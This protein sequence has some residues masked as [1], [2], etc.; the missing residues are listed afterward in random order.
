[1]QKD[2]L[3]ELTPAEIKRYS[4][5][6]IIEKV[7]EI[8]QRKLKAASVLIIGNGGLGSP[9]ALYLAA[10]GIGHIGLV[11]F[12]TVD[13]SNLQ[14]QVIH[15]THNIG[16]LKVDS[17]KKRM[18]SINPTMQIKTFPTAYSIENAEEIGAE[19]DL[20]LDGS[21]NFQTRYLINDYCVLHKKPYVYGSVFE[22]EG[23]V[24]VFDAQ[25][26]P[27]YRCIFPAPPPADSIPKT[28]GVFGVLPGTIGTIQSAEAIKLILGIGET[29]QG[30]LMLYDAL[31][32]SFHK[33]QIGKNPDCAVCGTTPEIQSLEDGSS[34]YR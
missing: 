7:G 33:I 31:D 22:F 19:Y 15:D 28:I 20:I 3:P 34:F 2:I 10:A 8:G 12:D 27:C 29:L 5:H 13:D 24:S 1:M 14:R 26:G 16:N 25:T 4:R 17:A 30:Y 6:T 21:D 11:D 18:L 23:Q 32:S 9:I